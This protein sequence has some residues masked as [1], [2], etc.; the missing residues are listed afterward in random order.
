M[1]LALVGGAILALA[2]T[3]CS[4]IKPKTQDDTATAT[5]SAETAQ[6]TTVNHV[7]T[8]AKFECN[9]GLTVTAQRISPEQLQLTTQ[10]YRGVLTLAPA[11]SGERFVATQGLFGYGGEWHQKGNDAVFSYKGIH[12]ADGQTQCSVTH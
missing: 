8:T 5:V 2:M 7:V 4:I 12:G 9:N 10:Q 1:K 3:G 6:Q 11:A